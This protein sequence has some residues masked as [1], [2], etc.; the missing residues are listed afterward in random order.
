MPV[1]SEATGLTGPQTVLV[2][3][4]DE[5]DRSLLTQLF[6][7]EGY[8]VDVAFDA[9]SALALATRRPP[10]LLLLDADLPGQSGFEV[11]RRVRQNSNTRL[12]PIIMVTAVDYRARRLEGFEAGADEVLLKP[13]DAE[14]L[15][16]RARSLAK[17]KRYTDDLDSAI[18]ILTTLAT[19]IERRDGDP[20]G[21]C[22][23]MAN[24]AV[25]LGRAMQV[26]EADAQVLYRGGY[27]HDVGMLAVSDLV[28]RKRGPLTPA[29][30]EQVKAHTVFGDELCANLR[31]LQ[32]IRPLI[33]WH[34]ERLDG[35]GYPDGLRGDEIPILAQIVGVVDVFEAVTTERPYQRTR[36]SEGAVEILRGE[37]QRGW[38]RREIVEAFVSLV[39]AQ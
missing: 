10:D 34:H 27:L 33:R 11:C 39:V 35:S 32:P 17:I 19:M 13:V 23:R 2:A 30:F 29:E 38:R 25:S 14:D 21:H 6:R 31:S 24:Y 5:H 20:P 26:N 12:T 4:G 1:L 9:A 36:S 16:V 28:L 3:E 37:V 8:T 22:E 7:A 18:A 15:L